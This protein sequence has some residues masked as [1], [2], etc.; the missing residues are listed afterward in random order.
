MQTQNTFLPLN[1]EIKCVLRL[2]FGKSK[3]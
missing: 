2:H 1:T 3:M